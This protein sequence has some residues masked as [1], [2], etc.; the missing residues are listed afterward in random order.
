MRGEDLTPFPGQL[1]Q[2]RMAGARPVVPRMR[3]QQAGGPQLMRVAERVGFAQAS[4]T[5]Q[6]LRPG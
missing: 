3:G 4:A 2:A 6:A 5:S 1:R